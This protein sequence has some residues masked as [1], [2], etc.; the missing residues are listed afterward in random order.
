MKASSRMALL[1]T[2]ASSETRAGLYVLQRHARTLYKRKNE[3]STKASLLLSITD[4]F[5]Y[6]F[7]HSLH[8]LQVNDLKKRVGSNCAP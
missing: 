5:Y 3:I 7:S 2:L 1:L 4:H 8:V 6:T